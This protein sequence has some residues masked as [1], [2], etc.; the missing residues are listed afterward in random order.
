MVA[1]VRGLWPDLVMPVSAWPLL[2]SLLQMG[3]HSHEL[4]AFLQRL[5]PS[6]ALH[7]GSSAR[8][9]RRDVVTRRVR[10]DPEAR[11]S[12]RPDGRSTGKAPAASLLAWRRAAGHRWSAKQRLL[13][14]GHQEPRSVST[15]TREGMGK[16]TPLN[17]RCAVEVSGHAM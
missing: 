3:S 17:Q 2:S 12:I 5:W 8:T 1:A 7:V 4:Q 11:H 13:H 6:A 10:G 9:S 15:T 14:R 16:Q